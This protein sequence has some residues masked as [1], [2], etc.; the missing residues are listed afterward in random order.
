MPANLYGGLHEMEFRKRAKRA[1]AEYWNKNKTLVKKYGDIST[2]KVFVVWQVKVIQ[3]SKALLGVNIEGDGLYF[4][5][6]WD[7]DDQVAYLDVYAKKDHYTL[8]KGNF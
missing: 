8:E 7:G 1:V 6:T 2:Q 5:Y 4:E 3:N